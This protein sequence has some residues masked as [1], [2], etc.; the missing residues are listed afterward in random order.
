MKISLAFVLC[1]LIWPSSLWAQPDAR[2]FEVGAS[3]VMVRF[4]DFDPLDEDSRRRLPN[5]RFGPR[6]TWLDEGL[7]LRVTWHAT[8][9]LGVEAEGSL[10]LGYAGYRGIEFRG[11]IKAQVL[12]GTRY[13]VAGRRAG[14][15]GKVRGGA[16][17]FERSPAIIGVSG[18]TPPRLIAAASESL[19]TR[20]N[21]QITAGLGFRFGAPVID[22]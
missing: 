22:R 20:H 21:L 19:F 6:P 5:A 18:P 8:R 12:A 17:V 3:A 10:L 9:R 11:G 15:F 4:V 14:V 7:A 13:G 1:V 2:R 16:M